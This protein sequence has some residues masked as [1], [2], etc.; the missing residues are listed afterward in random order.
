MKIVACA[1]KVLSLVSGL[2]L[3]AF[4]LSISFVSNIGDAWGE[5]N[6]RNLYLDAKPVFDVRYR[7]ER[8]DQD[9]VSRNAKANTVRTRAGFETGRFYGFGVGFDVEWIEG[10][11]S[12][13]YNDTINGKT[14][15]PVVADP[16]DEQINQLFLVSENTIPDTAFKLGRQRIIWDNARFIGNVG[17]RQNEQT[18]DAFRGS[19]TAIP[20]TMIEYTYLNEVRRIFGTDSPQGDF[21]LDSHGFR[22]GS[23]GAGAT[24]PS[25]PGR[26]PGSG[27]HR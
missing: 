5:E 9:S 20:D 2:I 16:D 25:Y 26:R 24:V 3:S 18:F 12:E 6:W 21:G 7:F 14:Q 23:P 17:F 1:M 15:Y 4:C 8:V 27:T 10:I 13:K 22:A 11:G 19:V